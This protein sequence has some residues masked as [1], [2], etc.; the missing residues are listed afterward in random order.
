MAPNDPKK[1]IEIVNPN[2]PQEHVICPFIGNLPIMVGGGP[3]GQGRPEILPIGCQKVACIFYSKALE[4][5]KI[6]IV[7]DYH[8]IKNNL[9]G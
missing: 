1:K 9:L 8:I 3:N 4:K 6:E 2:Q 7:L 5:C